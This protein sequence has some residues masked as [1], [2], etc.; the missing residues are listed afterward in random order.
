MAPRL[1]SLVKPPIGFA[2]RG[3]RAY[4][5][6]NTL[7]AFTRAAEMGATGLESDAWLTADGVAVL[8]HDGVVR[9]GLRRVPLAQVDRRDLPGHIPTLEALDATCGTDLPLS[10]DVK[11]PDAAGPVVD[12]ARAAG[13]RA[14]EQLWLCHHD[15]ETVAA[16]RPLDPTLKLVDSTRVRRMKQGPERRAAQLAHAGVDAVNLHHSEWSGGLV[17]LFHRF[18]LY[19]L[20]WDAQ[21]ERVIDALFDEGVDGVFSDYPDRLVAALGRL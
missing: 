7:G 6:E 20:G 10:L 2:H 12:V 17:S 19:V 8:D 4:E 14:L 15:W 21:H 1:P 18:E 11:D 3:A 13:G 5:Q 9:Q 16:W